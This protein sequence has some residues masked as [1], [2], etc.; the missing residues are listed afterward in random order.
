MRD[1]VTRAAARRATLVAVPLALVVGVLVFWL[2]GN[3]GRPTPRSSPTPV[4]AA[5]GPVE[6]AAPPLTERAATICR[7]LL[8][9][10][11]DS[12]DRL[13]RRPVTAGDRQNAA[14]GDPPVTLACA[15]GPPPSV[16]PDAQVLGLSGV[17]WG[18][19]ERAD[20]SVWTTVD[21]EVPV[22][23]TVP[24][25]YAGPSQ[26]VIDFAGPIVATVPLAAYV[27]T[28]CR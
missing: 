9:R 4:P 5:T 23:V 11:P 1:E 22:T 19:E 3:A 27:P 28:G 15:A 20:G 7:A 21:R 13:T 6:M 2:L 12:L 10:L 14:Y 8:L 24:K 18:T 26:K 16:A 25:A 17:C